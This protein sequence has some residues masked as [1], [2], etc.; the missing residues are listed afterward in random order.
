M[1]DGTLRLIV[2]DVVPDV[3][4]GIEENVGNSLSTADS[5]IAVTVGIYHQGTQRR[6][7]AAQ[8]VAPQ[9]LREN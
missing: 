2:V 6:T 1:V 7:L 3:E 5:F 8:M 9:G 4:L